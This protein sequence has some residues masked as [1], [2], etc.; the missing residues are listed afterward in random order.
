VRVEITQKTRKKFEMG[1]KKSCRQQKKG[2]DEENLD[3]VAIK[4]EKGVRKN[5]FVLRNENWS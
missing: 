3:A 5:G 2:Y 4:C 1:M